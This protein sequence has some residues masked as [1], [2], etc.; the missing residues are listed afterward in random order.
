M[1]RKETKHK[2]EKNDEILE[3]RHKSA[4]DMFKS[5]GILIPITAG[6]IDWSYC[7][8]VENLNEKQK[9]EELE[10]QNRIAM[11]NMKSKKGVI[12]TKFDYELMLMG[13]EQCSQKDGNNLLLFFFQ[14]TVLTKLQ[15]NCKKL[16]KITKK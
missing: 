11:L 16:Q 6:G 14:K 3:I 12:K 15:K 4:I 10:F 2:K 13:T 7:P 5:L 9:K 1:R 8:T